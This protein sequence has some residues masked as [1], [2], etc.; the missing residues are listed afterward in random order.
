MI[1]LQYFNVVIKRKT[2]I[3]EEKEEKIGSM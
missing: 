2:V 3:E 1:A